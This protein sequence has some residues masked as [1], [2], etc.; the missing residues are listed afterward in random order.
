MDAQNLWL[1]S[2]PALRGHVE[3]L[4]VRQLDPIPQGP[5]MPAVVDA[6]LS[7]PLPGSRCEQGPL[8]V[9]GKGSP[10]QAALSSH[11]TPLGRPLST[12][13]LGVTLS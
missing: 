5:R 3:P 13:P 4:S 2:A 1:D 10:R 12:Q 7:W 6:E 8:Q 11:C 9:S